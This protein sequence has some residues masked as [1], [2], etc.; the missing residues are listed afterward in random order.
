MIVTKPGLWPAVAFGAPR[1]KP[2]GALGIWP[3]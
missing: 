2:E 1:P 3:S